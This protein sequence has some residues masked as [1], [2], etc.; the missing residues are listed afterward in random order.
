MMLHV[1]MLKCTHQ[2][3]AKHNVFILLLAQ[4]NSPSVNYYL[5]PCLMFLVI[6]VRLAP[7]FEGNG[8]FLV[9]VTR[10]NVQNSF[11]RFLLKPWGFLYKDPTRLVKKWLI[12]D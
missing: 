9:I 6:Q 3:V 8:V 10:Y 12:H 7:A 4:I 5:C 11:E 2:V 1:S